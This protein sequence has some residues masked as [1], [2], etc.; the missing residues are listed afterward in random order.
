MVTLPPSTKGQ[1]NLDKP[2]P[3]YDALYAASDLLH[4]QVPNIPSLQVGTLLHA[5]FHARLPISAVL[6]YL[7]T[8]KVKFKFQMNIFGVW[9]RFCTVLFK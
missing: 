7:M 8:K 4:T 1:N 2:P 9:G 5:W 3:K 6:F